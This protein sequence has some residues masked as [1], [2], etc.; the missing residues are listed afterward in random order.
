MRLL[1]R[2]GQALLRN[3]ACS[4]SSVWRY[5][6]LKGRALILPSRMYLPPQTPVRRSVTPSSKQRSFT[7]QEEHRDWAFQSSFRSS[8]KNTSGSA[9]LHDMRSEEH[10]SELQSRFDLVCRILLDA[11]NSTV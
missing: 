1:S 2:G 9:F 8:G 7:G 4:N 11:K 3:S 10:T 5:A 6:P